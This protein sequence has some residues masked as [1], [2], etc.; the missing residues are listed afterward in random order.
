MSVAR[1]G[2]LP[3]WRSGE[4]ADLCEQ[5]QDARQRARRLQ[6]QLRREG[7]GKPS[8]AERLELTRL[9]KLHQTLVQELQVPCL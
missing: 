8:E 5:L 6:E 9:G 4:L 3:D 7:R 1:A 2:W